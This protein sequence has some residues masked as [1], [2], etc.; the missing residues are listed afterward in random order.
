MVRDG[1][2]SALE[3]RLALAGMGA[4]EIARKASL[5]A[6]VSVALGRRPELW[7][8]VPGRI[9]LLGKHTDYAG[10]RS[11]LC[12]TE[13][14]FAVVAAPRDDRAVRL[15]DAVS[16]ER[17]DLVP[18]ASLAPATGSWASYASAVVRR[19]AR[20]FP[21]PLRGADVAFASD[22]PRAAGLS[23]SSALV[24]ATFLVI[25]DLNALAARGEYRSAIATADDLAGYLG[26]IENGTAFGAL[27]GDAGV[28][29]F[30]GSEDHTAILCARAG[31]LVQYSFAPV[32]FERRVPLPADHAFVVAA[33]GVVAEKAGA[34][35]ELYNA[36]ARRA[37][38]ILDRWCAATG[39]TDA[40]LAAA[41][42]SSAGA[43]ERMRSMLRGGA[44][45]EREVIE[46]FP[47]RDLV[48]RFDQFAME[49][50][51]LVPAVGDALSRGA[52][53][54][55]GELVDRSQRAAE[56]L[57]GNQV[58][59]TIHL[60]QS[61]RSLGAAAASAF[62]AGFGGSVWALVRR[63]DLEA[64]TAAWKEAYGLAFP[65]RASGASFFVTNA[66]PAA[67]RL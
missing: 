38:V 45:R 55:L 51:E 61:A 4:G 56:A 8:W 33:S 48:A 22:L 57:L 34:A 7:L 3:E 62:G 6:Q 26:A 47:T 32:H 10:G 36:Q 37:R 20:N 53:E 29:T 50:E 12:A 28:G 40:T 59:E 16:G 9:E 18:G 44:E 24:T 67:V 19:I 65:E 14:G 11:L 15:V 5:F 23:S 30:G 2:G 42:A 54:A 49:S 25:A 35:L 66:G 64:F 46:G 31:A 13:R 17:L 1:A 63:D 58:P 60:A 41:L 52:L 27:E 43:R 39:R 21:G